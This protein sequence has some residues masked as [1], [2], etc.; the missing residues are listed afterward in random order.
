MS[1]DRKMPRWVPI[2]ICVAIAA[3]IALQFIGEGGNE[4]PGTATTAQTTTTPSV[5]ENEQETP[6]S[7]AALTYALAAR[8]WTPS[9]F[10]EQYDIRIGLA[11]GRL[12]ADLRRFAPTNADIAQLRLDG[13]SAG[14]T[15]VSVTRVRETA[16]D[17]KYLVVLDERSVAV[18]QD[19]RARTTNEVTLKH[20]ADGWRVSGFTIR[21]T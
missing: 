1:S 14:A 21:P 5:V 16:S 12:R 15:L 17:A 20:R 19:V 3:L 7:R 18:G 8:T 9:T 2:V 4:Q 10:R 6:A 13:A 11:T